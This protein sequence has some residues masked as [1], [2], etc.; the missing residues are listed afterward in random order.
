M[1]MLHALNNNQM[2]HALNNNFEAIQELRE[3]GY[4][5]AGFTVKK[6]KVMY[7][8][9]SKF[10]WNGIKTYDAKE[11]YY[12]EDTGEPI[13][14][15]G[16]RYNPVQY[17]MMI[18]KVRD[19]IERSDLDAT[20]IQEKISVSPN[21]GMCCVEYILPA[22]KFISPDGDISYTRLM[23]LSSFN[24]VWSF[25]LTVGHMLRRCM[26]GQIFIKNPAAIYK[27]RHTNK[28]DIDFGVSVLGKVIN[29]VKDEV[30][31]WHELA[32]TPS[33]GANSN[34][35]VLKSFAD[36][37][38]YKD[39]I[40][41]ISWSSYKDDMNNKA[42]IYLMDRYQ[43]HYAPLMGRNMWAV[44]NTITDWSTHAPSRSKDSIALMQRR[45]EKATESMTK[46]LLAA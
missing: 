41:E 12:R 30:D 7:H 29:T 40:D 14:I 27:A 45:T 38:N 36:I 37:A 6:A 33:E 31:F 22:E 5:D 26:N 4:G 43:T 1:Q 8:A 10:N 9:D 24:G 46:Y 17:P 11:V 13:A 21:G 42:M 23:A 2:L 15:H 44:Y 18:D 34:Q 25:I 39:D 3:S 28:L 16:L 35:V 19:M 20:G 32:N